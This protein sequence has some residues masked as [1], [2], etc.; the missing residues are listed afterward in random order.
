LKSFLSDHNVEKLVPCDSTQANESLHGMV[1]AVASK[2]L[3]FGRGNSWKYRSTLAYLK[4][5]FGPKYIVPIV[6]KLNTKIGQQTKKWIVKSTKSWNWHK[7]H[8]LK[9]TTK[10]R[11][12]YLKKNRKKKDKEEEEEDSQANI[13]YQS[14]IGLQEQTEERKLQKGDQSK[15]RKRRSEQE[16][17]KARRFKCPKCDKGYIQKQGLKN[18]KCKSQG[19]EEKKGEQK[20]EVEEDKENEEGKEMDVE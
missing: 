4:K 8:K 5:N 6:S 16:L 17:E 18:H 12:S 11:R 20:E 9:A 2:R 14:G 15:K 1:G 10:K 13:V 7:K 19:I 3:F